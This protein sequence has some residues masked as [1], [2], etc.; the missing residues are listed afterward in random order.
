[1]QDSVQ[2]LPPFAPENCNYRFPAIWYPQLVSAHSHPVPNRL[3]FPPCWFALTSRAPVPVD[4]SLHSTLRRAQPKRHNTA[5]LRYTREVKVEVARIRSQTGAHRSQRW[6][7]ANHSKWWDEICFGDVWKAA[8][9][10]VICTY[11][12]TSEFPP[13]P[14]FF[15]SGNIRR[16][17]IWH[18]LTRAFNLFLESVL[19]FT[20]LRSRLSLSMWK[21]IAVYAFQ[22]CTLYV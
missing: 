1:M 22:K 9:R 3:H 17:K 7:A 4:V 6:M 11:V 13:F 2:P 16:L 18:R 21:W 5:G 15:C 20:C 19:L 12:S 8:H 10:G 14:L